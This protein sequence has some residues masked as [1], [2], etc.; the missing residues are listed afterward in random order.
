MVRMST[1]APGRPASP[2]TAQARGYFPELDVLRGVAIVFVIY[3]HAYF[4]AWEVTP[5]RE[6]VA[7]HTIHLFAHAAVPVFLFVSGFL[8]AGEPPAPFREFAKRKG[9]ALGLP[10]VVWMTAAFAYRAWDEGGI[11]WR[12]VRALLLFDISGQYY[13]LFVLAVFLISGFFVRSW[14]ATTLG[15]VAAAAFVVNLATVLYYEAS[16]LTGTFA[17]LAY[18]NPLS[19]VF[20]FVLGL[21]IARGR[22][23]LELPGRLVATGAL[24]MAGILLAYLIQGEFFDYYPVSYFGVTTFLFSCLSVVVYPSLAHGLVVT[25]W[26]GVLLSPFRWLSRY[27]FAVYLVHMPFFVGYV[28]NR[29]VTGSSLSDDYFKLMNSLFA[30]GFISSLAFVVAVDLVAPRWLSQ[31][32][33]VERPRKK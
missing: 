18:R 27:A 22:G 16:E 17:T 14:S 13:Y 3:L 23:R 10:L 29:Y 31:M 32:A 15:R 8:L 25:P 30:V 4:S 11:S 28:T 7:M 20:F 6:V 19:W 21:F 33:G 9:V 2:T 24:G 26:G 1:V 5:R 12:L